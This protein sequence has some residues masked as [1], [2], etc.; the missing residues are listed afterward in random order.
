MAGS[1]DRLGNVRKTLGDLNG[2]EE[3]YQ[4]EL[5]LSERLAE[6]TGTVEAQRDLAGSYN[7]LGILRKMC[8]DLDEA[9]ELYERSL[10]LRKRL[11]EETRTVESYYSLA[12]S[13]F[14][15]AVIQQPY[16][17]SLLEEA[18]QITTALA[19]RCPQITQYSELRDVIKNIFEQEQNKIS[20]IL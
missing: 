18:L 6:E 17:W 7:N 8:G 10:A 16:H 1:Y 12:I 19:A 15:I 11:A 4:K 5:T 3:F 13:Y 20:G 2:A 14:N 9:E